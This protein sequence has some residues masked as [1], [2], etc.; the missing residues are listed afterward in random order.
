MFG[1]LGN[2]QVALYLERIAKGLVD[3]QYDGVISFESVYCLDGGD[4]EAGFRE[5]LAEFKRLFGWN[6]LACLVQS[7]AVY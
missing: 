2:G 1:A 6:P 4:F 7:T 3:G 5:S